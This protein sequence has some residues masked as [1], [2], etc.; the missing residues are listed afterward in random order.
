MR[1]QARSSAGLRQLRSLLLGWSSDDDPGRRV[2]PDHF[3]SE[4][5]L[6][7]SRLQGASGT[8]CRPTYVEAP[9]IAERE[10]RKAFKA[11]EAEKAMT[12]HAKEQKDF[13]ENRERLKA[14]RLAR[15]AEATQ[16][17]KPNG[18]PRSPR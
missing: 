12:D 3:T 15:E 10:A 7:A 8:K 13:H 9:A 16:P 4:Q 18:E 11:V 17:P 1:Y 5:A 2:R 6:A 14:E